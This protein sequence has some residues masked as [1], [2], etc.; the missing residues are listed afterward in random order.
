MNERL[1]NQPTNRPTDR[2]TDQRTDKASYRVACP[3][4]KRT[5]ERNEERETEKA[6]RAN[7]CACWLNDKS[8]TDR[9]TDEHDLNLQVLRRT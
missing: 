4:L 9:Q 8:M 2:P 7:W 1:L 5:R 6:R 3:R